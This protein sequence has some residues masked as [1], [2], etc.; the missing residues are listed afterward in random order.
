[1]RNVEPTGKAKFTAPRALLSEDDNSGPGGPTLLDPGDGEKVAPRRGSR[2]VG[3]ARGS[4]GETGGVLGTR[5]GREAPGGLPEIAFPAARSLPK[6]STSG[7]CRAR[8]PNPQRI[9]SNGHGPHGSRGVGFTLRHSHVSP[10]ICD[11]S[12]PN[13]W[14]LP[15]NRPGAARPRLDQADDLRP[16]T[17]EDKLRAG[18]SLAKAFATSGRLTPQI[19]NWC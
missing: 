11:P 16:A 18:Y 17:D 1:M 14:R 13:Q 6:T 19:E 15:G 5:T 4:Q 12:L 8:T 2:D 10:Y 9:M 7:D 3:R